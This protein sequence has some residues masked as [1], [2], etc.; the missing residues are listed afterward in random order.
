M[1][2]RTTFNLFAENPKSLTINP[3]HMQVTIRQ[4]GGMEY[5][6]ADISVVQG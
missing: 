1:N 2:I 6:Y 4:K 3:N 5:L